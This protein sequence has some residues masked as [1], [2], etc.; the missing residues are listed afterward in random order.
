LHC[1]Y[2]VDLPRGVVLMDTGYGTVTDLRTNVTALGLSY[3][4]GIQPQ[5][6]GMGAPWHSRQ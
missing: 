3:V 2:A 6:V 4:A 1:A 5:T